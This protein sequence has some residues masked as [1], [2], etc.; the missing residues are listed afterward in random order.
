M[1]EHHSEPPLSGRDFIIRL[2]RH[3]GLI[4]VVLAV[5]LAAGVI[6]YHELARMSWVD[7]FLNAA[8]ILGGMGQVGELPDATAKIFAG[9]YALY[10]G[11]ILIVAAGIMLAP[12]AHRILHKLHA[13]DAG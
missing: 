13:E 10:S 1:Y 9:C 6:G 5:S 3:G 11:I 8:M 7:A 12:V 4:G 2:L